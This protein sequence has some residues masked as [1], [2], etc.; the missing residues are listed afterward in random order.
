MTVIA[1]L[2]L[3]GTDTAATGSIQTCVLHVTTLQGW[4][5]TE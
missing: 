1:I 3:E 2:T 4:Q 5:R